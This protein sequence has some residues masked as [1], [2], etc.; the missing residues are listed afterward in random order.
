MK[1][2][3]CPYHSQKSKIT[4]A[5]IEIYITLHEKTAPLL[6][7][8]VR[9][10]TVSVAYLEVCINPRFSTYNRRL[11]VILHCVTPCKDHLVYN[12]TVQTRARYLRTCLIPHTLGL[13]ATLQIKSRQQIAFHSNMLLFFDSEF[14]RQHSYT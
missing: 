14:S 7:L 2:Y 5:K 3:L 11:H 9:D 10:C 1:E 13:K 12:V 8:A 6:C 4:F